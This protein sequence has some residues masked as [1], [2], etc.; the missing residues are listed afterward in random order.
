MH[1]FFLM[2]VC[3]LPLTLAG[4]AG[5]SVERN[6]ERMNG[7]IGQNEEAVIKA[8]GVPGK[9]YKLDSG[10]KIISY[11]EFSG[12]FDSPTS[13]V[14]IGSFPGNFGYSTCAGSPSRRVR[15][16]CERSFHLKGGKVVD[17]SQHG[18]NCPGGEKG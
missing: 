5:A 11:D 3:L 8:W 1:R 6:S 7:Y 9:V 10:I 12:R 2:I 4:C 18:N 14:C 16:S 17:W 15:L 13:T